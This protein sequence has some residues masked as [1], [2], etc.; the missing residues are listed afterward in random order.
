MDTVE[1]N[2]KYREIL[3]KNAFD[4]MKS[5]QREYSKQSTL[6]LPREMV[7]KDKKKNIKK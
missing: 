7:E 5:N 6:Y 4:I 2:Q 3:V 1:T